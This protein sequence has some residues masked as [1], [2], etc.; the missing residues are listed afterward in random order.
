[1]IIIQGHKC[2]GIIVLVAF[3]FAG[4]YLC[5]TDN[6]SAEPIT[7]TEGGATYALNEEGDI[8][9]ATAVWDGNSSEVTIEATVTYDEKTYSV[10][11]V[12]AFGKNS[13][14]TKITIKDNDAL[15]L[16]ENTFKANSKL[17]TL[18]LG[19]GL[20]SLP[21]GFCQETTSLTAL[22]LS[23]CSKLLSIGDNAF[24]KSGLKSIIIPNTVQSLGSSCFNKCTALESV[25]LPSEAKVIPDHAFSGCSKL[26]SVSTAGIEVF[27]SYS[28][29]NCKELNVIDTASA[30]MIG[31]YAFSSCTSLTTVVIPDS[32]AIGGMGEGCFNKCTALESATLPTTMKVIPASTFDGCKALSSV[33]MGQ[34]EDFLDNAFSGCESLTSIDLSSAKTIGGSAFSACK[35]LDTV[36]FPES[37][38]CG[39]VCF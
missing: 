17:A 7:F 32:L 21:N 34:V 9:T 26:A 30:K 15:T 14:V 38:G 28:F 25:I 20:T 29:A 23:G 12:S 27:E 11:N 6:S 37:G 5:F 2:A 24:Y 8:Y 13:K 35:S 39:T 36:I 16:S 19:D 4:I 31:S 3:M 18:V 1:V 22:D 10:T 33:S